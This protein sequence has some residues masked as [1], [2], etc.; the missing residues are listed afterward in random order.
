MKNIIMK[1]A[2][3]ATLSLGSVSVFTEALKAKF[4]E[5][6]ATVELQ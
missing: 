4:A 3:A 5:V 1:C 6:G 2:L